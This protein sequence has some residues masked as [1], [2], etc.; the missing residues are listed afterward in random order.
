MGDQY[1]DDGAIVVLPKWAKF[2]LA[3][4]LDEVYRLMPQLAGNECAAR[5]AFQRALNTHANPYTFYVGYFTGPTVLEGGEG[6]GVEGL[7]EEEE[8]DVPMMEK[9]EE[10]EEEPEDNAEE[11]EGSAVE[12]AAAPKPSSKPSRQDMIPLL[13]SLFMHSIDTVT[14][15]TAVLLALFSLRLVAEWAQ[16]RPRL[17]HGFYHGVGDV[18]NYFTFGSTRS[19]MFCG[20]AKSAGG[21]GRGGPV[22]S[23]GVPSMAQ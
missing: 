8:E 16:Q 23:A 19:T 12:E 20:A 3:S 17:F 5:G 18:L 11:D 2:R 6:K 4:L 7:E 13:L 22:V 10:E 1:E 9:E 21:G 15:A 14:Y